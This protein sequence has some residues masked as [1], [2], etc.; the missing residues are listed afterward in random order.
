MCPNRKF[1]KKCVRTGDGIKNPERSKSSVG[2]LSLLR[3]A[4][5][6]KAPLRISSLLISN[7]VCPHNK[8]C[9][10]S[11]AM[12]YTVMNRL[13]KD[14]AGD[15]TV[16]II[17]LLISWAGEIASQMRQDRVTVYGA[18][19]AFF[20]MISA[21]PFVMLSVALLQFIM[22]VT[23]SQLSRLAL[24]VVPLSLRSYVVRIIDELYNQT[25][26]PL[27]SVTAASALWAASR[28][29]YALA[30]GLKE[31]YDTVETRGYVKL[32]ILALLH[33]LLLLILLLFS[34][35]ILVFGNT[36]Q[37]LLEQS[38]PILAQIS[39]YIISARTLSQDRQ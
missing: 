30:G 22:P 32:R 4:T 2:A 31:I 9:L 8:K 10:K 35:V 25:S 13:S 34:L 15:L 37:L 26:V 11:L 39:A 19:A 14:K 7:P 17:K 36:L 21:I 6:T 33:T 27:I 29:L 5:D 12:V 23:Q 3:S 1:F 24:D 20:V 38:L 16:A 28:S 18:Q